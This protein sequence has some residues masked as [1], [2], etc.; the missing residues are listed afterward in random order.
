MLIGC[1]AMEEEEEEEEAEEEGVEEEMCDS[2]KC[3]LK[4]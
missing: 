2:A 1:L 3:C 4:G